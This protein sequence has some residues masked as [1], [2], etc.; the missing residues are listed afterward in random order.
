LTSRE[1]QDI[2]TCC[3]SSRP[4]WRPRI[5]SNANPG[6]VGHAWYRA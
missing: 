5:H 2:A 3:R 6:G 1:F 4:G